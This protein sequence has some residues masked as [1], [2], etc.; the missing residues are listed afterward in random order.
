MKKETTDSAILTA[1]SVHL[2]VNKKKIKL[3]EG[4]TKLSG[5]CSEKQAPGLGGA[6][7]ACDCGYVPVCFL[8]LF[9][10]THKHTHTPAPTHTRPCTQRKRF[11][12]TEK[13]MLN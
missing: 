11:A 13:Q 1:R 8:I 7:D 10:Y 3:E 2:F 9:S 5:V 6:D 12:S 4:G